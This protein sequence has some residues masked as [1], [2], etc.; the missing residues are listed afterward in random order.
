MRDA[1]I[2]ARDLTR[3]TLPSSGSFPVVIDAGDLRQL[4]SPI[5][6][7]SS[8]RSIYQKSSRFELGKALPGLETKGDPLN[9][10]SNA[11]APFGLGSYAFDDDGV[12]A[13]R[14]EVVTNGVFQRPWADQQSAAYTQLA[15]TG[16]F[17]NL[18]IAP[19]SLGFDELL[20]G[21]PLLYVRGFSWLT[22]DPGRGDFSSEIRIGYW[23]DAKDGVR[24]RE[25]RSA[26][27]SSPGC[28]M[29][30][31]LARPRWSATIA[32]RARCASRGWR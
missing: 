29:R 30:A 27:I 14:V 25:A 11:I 15:A 22:P 16:A 28:R 10:S 21:G 4:F 20:S 32:G 26:G 3:A 12:P 6:Q 24:S 5:V 13:Q 17:A 9:L 19:G 18:E 23:I 31:S 8:A 7:S 2:E 1:A